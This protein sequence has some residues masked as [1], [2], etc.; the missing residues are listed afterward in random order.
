M[1]EITD[2]CANANNEDCPLAKKVK[3]DEEN[4]NEKK[5]IDDNTNE[6]N[7]SD[8]KV[9]KILQN[10]CAR[11]LICVEGTFEGREGSA[12]V[13]LEQKS[14]S[15]DTS[16][17]KKTFFDEDTTFRKIFTNDIYRTYICSPAKDYNSLQATVI[18][19]ATQTHIDKYKKQDV[20][21]ID[22]TYDLYQQVTLPH[23]ES[24]SL[25][26]EWI[27]NILEHKAE[28]ESV[29]YED[30]DKETGFILVTD[31]KWNK[32]PDTLKLLA[33][34]FKKIRSLRELNASH[35]PLLRNIQD[36]GIAAINKKFNIPKSQLRIYFHYQ[37]SYYYLHV[38]F[39]YLMF[40]APGI[41]VEKAHL[42]STVINNLEL[43]PDYYMKAVLSYVVFKG[44]P[45]YEKFKEHGTLEM[46]SC[47][48]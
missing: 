42:L 23:I 33:L 31:F 11:K 34:P 9:A 3:L 19:P 20:Y 26:L 48:T 45:L 12:V 38:H 2:K 18:H 30:P 22:E 46:S 7:L 21:M 14:F 5:T 27:T 41:F 8:F 1:A 15:Y 35:L 29:I 25:S 13:L 24:T 10:N 16:V 43:M 40:E 4:A 36:A 32:E 6:L 39:C 44:S 28:Q 47:E 37:P 17:L